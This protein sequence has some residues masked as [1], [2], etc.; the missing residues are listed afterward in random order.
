MNNRFKIIL[1]YILAFIGSI[2]LTLLVAVVIV[3]FTVLN[4]QYVKDL[5]EKNNYYTNVSEEINDKMKYYMESSGLPE[6]ILENLYSKEELKSDIVLF[7][8]N[9]Y[10]GNKIKINVDKISNRLNKNIDDYLNDHDVKVTSQSY[11]NSFVNNMSSI[12]E[13]E[14]NLYGM[15]NGFILY[16]PKVMSIVNMLLLVLSVIL[17][18]IIMGLL[19]LKVN[20]IGSLVMASGL[21]IMFVK[22]LFNE[23]IDY[24][25]ILIISNNFSNIIKVFIKNI[26]FICL[27][28][29]VILVIVGLLVNIIKSYKKFY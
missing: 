21:I 1:G 26:G 28:S 12:Y 18:I 3:K 17:I 8:D 29:C 4:K 7:I 27:I 9:A 2:I 22:L 5:L 23:K 14:V 20:Y 10:D 11:I 25:N 24:Q 15:V 19:L 6:N 16:V 13:K